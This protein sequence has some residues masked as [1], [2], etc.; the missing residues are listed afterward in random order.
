[1]EIG[2][3]VADLSS[4]RVLELAER[5]AAQDEAEQHQGSNAL[6]DAVADFLGR[7][8]V[9]P[10][11]EALRATALWVVHSHVP[12]AFDT[13]PRL[14]AISPEKR[15]GKTRLLE[16]LTLLC[17]TA[18][19]A[20]NIS[21]AAMFRMVEKV[22]PTLLWDEAD[23]FFGPRAS[24]THEELRGLVNAGYRRGATAWRCVGDKQVPQ[25]FPAFCVVAMAGIG[26]LPDTVMDRAVVL[27]MRRRY[28]GE[29]MERFRYRVVAPQGEELCERLSA[30]AGTDEAQSLSAQWPAMP[31]GLTDRDEDT[32]E[33]LLAIADVVGGQWPEWSRAAAVALSLERE[34]AEKSWGI[35]L[36]E[37]LRTVF[38]D[39]EKMSTED[40]LARLRKLEEA[41]WGDIRGKALDARGLARRLRPFG[42][43]SDTV[44]IGE[45]TAKGYKRDDLF[46][47]WVRY[48]PSPEKASQ[49]SQGLQRPES[50][51]G[52]ADVPSHDGQPSQ[53]SLALTCDVTSVTDVTDFPENGLDCDVQG[54]A[55]GSHIVPVSVTEHLDPDGIVTDLSPDELD[56][57]RDQ[58][59]VDDAPELTDEELEC[60][61]AETEAFDDEVNS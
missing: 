43:S 42:V 2:C 31:E 25:E 24:S 58:V 39:A 20:V 61:Y 34:D 32:W 37:D 28:S 44:R 7:F 19:H 15:S 21:A 9:F 11:V 33:P 53:E 59:P 40:L 6:L 23:T 4:A 3:V 14:V 51:H 41:P 26:D 5:R 8:I 10:S 30:W 45:M 16:V 49:A 46:D 13:T 17:P 60:L 27:R 47:V 22:H 55:R 57:L 29:S 35:R 36:L 54:A 18:R 38:G 52:L 48:L 12:Y 56:R 50:L 1:M